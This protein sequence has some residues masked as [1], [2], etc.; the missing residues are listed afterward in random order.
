[1]RAVSV[2]SFVFAAAVFLSSTPALA[3]SADRE[4]SLVRDDSSEATASG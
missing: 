3:V 4:T 2:L 1:M